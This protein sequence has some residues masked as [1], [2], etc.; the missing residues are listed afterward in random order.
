MFTY[1]AFSPA[2]GIGVFVAIDRFNVSAAMTMSKVVNDLIG[3]LA[4]R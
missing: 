2:R 3:E 1:T 4:P